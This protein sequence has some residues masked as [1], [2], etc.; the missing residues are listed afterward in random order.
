[1]MKE[2][3]ESQ[4]GDIDR[5]LHRLEKEKLVVGKNSGVEVNISEMDVDEGGDKD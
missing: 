4:S 3:V 2:M 1:M 5:L